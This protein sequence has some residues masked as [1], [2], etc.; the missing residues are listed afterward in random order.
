MKSRELLKELEERFGETKEDLKF[1]STLEEI[2]S[3]FFIKDA[4]LSAG[5]I[6]FT[7]S[8]QLCSRIVDTYSSW[9]SHLHE[10]LIPNPQSM[11]GITESKALN[12]DDRKEIFNLIKKVMRLITTNSLVGLTK[13]KSREAKFIDDSV[14][15]WH[16]S[17]CP[18][19]VKIMEKLN[20]GW[21]E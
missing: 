20:K 12:E 9:T 21:G 16:K 14:E 13:D 5:F 2:D 15:F 19:L 7:F 1:K 18:R 6:S 8:R 4:I 3:I 17:F 10:L 11:I